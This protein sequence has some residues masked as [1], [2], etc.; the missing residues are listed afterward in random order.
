M[1]RRDVLQLLSSAG[2]AT[3]APLGSSARAQT[4]GRRYFVV[5]N[6]GGGWDPTS[7]CDP[8]GDAER[9]DGRGPVNHFF[10]S[11]IR[12]VGQGDI[13]Y[14]PFPAP[15]LATSTL[16]DDNP[17]SGYDDFFQAVG[18]ELLI[19]NGIDTETNNHETGSRTVWSGSDQQTQ[20]ALA[21]LIAQ[22]HAP[23]SPLA[24]ISNGGYDYTD[25]LIAPTRVSGTGIFRELS[26]PNRS[27]TNDDADLSNEQSFFLPDSIDAVIADAR[28]RRMQN[29]IAR[30]ALPQ[31]R[32][33]A[34]ALFTVQGGGGN[35][36]QLVE[37]LPSSV[38]AGLRGQAEIAVAAFQADVAVC[39]NLTSGGF[40]THGNHDRDATYRMAVLI[41]GV[42]HLWRSI[43]DAGL[44]DRTT[45]LVGS[46]F[47][48][49]PFYN[50]GNGK[51]HWNATSLM[52]FG[53]GV[54]GGRVVG[55]TDEHFVEQRIDPQSL[56]PSEG[57]DAIRLTFA[58]VHRAARRLAGIDNDAIA[59]TYPLFA[60]D[61]PIFG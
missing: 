52:A 53:A 3:I 16:R 32:A 25:G 10:A 24:F 47:G 20:P 48:R 31:R 26:Y 42:H 40:D 41:D 7:L 57:N 55:G 54:V 11:D 8:K 22:A 5:V 60:E 18:P 58:H 2:L 36:N 9:A 14:A 19:I 17:I 33:A 61:L 4:A 38:S 46:D 29:L 13:R 37:Y 59:R 6:A 23:S 51:D 49:T 15:E 45:V 43:G 28:A 27:N 34:N 1:N 56:R 44:A 30:S 35:L 21:A 39:A 50:D 12:R